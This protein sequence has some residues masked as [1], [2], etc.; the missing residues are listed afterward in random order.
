MFVPEWISVLNEL[1]DKWFSDSLIMT[2]NVRSWMN[3][4]FEWT[5]WQMIQWFTY[6]DSQCSFL[7]ESVFWTSWL[8]EWFTDC[9]WMNR[10]FEPISW[11]RDSIIVSELVFWRNRL[12][13]YF[14]DSLIKAASCSF[15]VLNKVFE[16]WFIRK[17][18]HLFIPEWISVLN[19]SVEPMIHWQRVTAK[20]P[21]LH[22]FKYQ[23]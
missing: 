1:V 18:S 15:S 8:K 2:V 13:E 14:G 4:C 16:E 3:Q 19:E 23:N 10:C 9:L 7:N 6:N 20:S 21:T 17:D 22:K 11:M 5:G 12:I